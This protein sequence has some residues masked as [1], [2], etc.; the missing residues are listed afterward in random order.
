MMR[1]VW[2]AARDAD[3]LLAIIDSS[4]QPE[5]DLQSLTQLFEAGEARNLPVALAR[6]HQ[7]TL[8]HVFTRFAFVYLF[9]A[10]AH[11]PLMTRSGQKI[12]WL[13]SGSALPV[14][15]VC[16]QVLNKVDLISED[17]AAEVL[18]RLSSQSSRLVIPTS[19]KMGSG[20]A[21]VKQWASEQLSEGPSLYPK[22]IPLQT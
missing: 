4:F 1:S 21:E 20:V 12:H 13:P 15:C 3:A 8:M 17:R 16:M 7:T 11:K 10:P 9:S 19:A 2:K 14:H 5:E 6:P 18:N 22:V